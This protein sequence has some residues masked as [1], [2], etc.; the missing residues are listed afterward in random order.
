MRP[1]SLWHPWIYSKDAD[2]LPIAAASLPTAMVRPLSLSP[3]IAKPVTPSI[4]NGDVTFPHFP[5]HLNCT[6]PTVYSGESV[7]S[8]SICF[9]LSAFASKVKAFYSSRKSVLKRF[10]P[11]APVDTFYRILIISFLSRT[12][13]F[14]RR[15]L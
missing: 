10:F 3:A 8:L 1:R 12:V 11:A 5:S 6:L 15:S 13:T 4:T 14:R 2:S 9:E 7:F